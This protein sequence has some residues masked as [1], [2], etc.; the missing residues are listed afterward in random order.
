MAKTAGWT[1][2][3]A[4][5]VD[6]AATAGRGARAWRGVGQREPLHRNPALLGTADAGVGFDDIGD[7]QGISSDVQAVIAQLLQAAG[8]SS[9]LLRVLHADHDLEPTTA[10]P[11]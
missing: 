5:R 8:V 1:Y 7:F 6:A 10:T 11:I 4:R 9:S 2:I 3:R